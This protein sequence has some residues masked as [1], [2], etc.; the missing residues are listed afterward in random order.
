ME[1]IWIIYNYKNELSGNRAISFTDDVEAK[2]WIDE[3]E[4]RINIVDI[5]YSA[6][7]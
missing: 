6:N 7:K 3:R 5:A 2:Q 4:D 1:K